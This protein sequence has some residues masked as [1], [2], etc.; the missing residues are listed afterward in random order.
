MQPEPSPTTGSF[1]LSQLMQG[2]RDTVALSMVSNCSGV[3][4]SNDPRAASFEFQ[5]HRGPVAASGP[6]GSMVIL[7]YL[8]P[9]VLKHCLCTWHFSL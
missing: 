4:A 1:S 3:D 2:S 8:V 9:Q 6:L 7:D 5:F